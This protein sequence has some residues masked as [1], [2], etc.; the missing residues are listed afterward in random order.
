M[1]LELR[2]WQGREQESRALAEMTAQWGRERG[3]AIL[4]VFALMGLTVLE[5]G[6]GRYAEALSS[7]MRIY[8]DDPPGFGNRILPEI[9]EAATRS[10]ERRTARAALD[11]L[12]DRATASGTPWALGMLARSRAL[13]APGSGAEAFYQEAVSHLSGTSVRT[14]LARTHLLYGEWLRRHKRRRDAR[15]QLRT[16]CDM[17]DAMGAAAFAGRTRAELLATGEILRQPQERPGPDLTP[18]EA[19]V[20][21]LATA[22]ATNAQ[23]AI[24]LFVTTSTVEYHLSKVFRKLGI[25]SR[26]Q[27]AAA[28]GH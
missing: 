4:E 11:R 20:V 17:F 9:V 25:T 18:Q 28:L 10:G 24:H 26:R 15:S 12:A 22:G 7:G 16:A 5:L 23:I 3:A 2:A 6:L 14:E 8:D 1:L 13:L 27:L 21:R 19:Q